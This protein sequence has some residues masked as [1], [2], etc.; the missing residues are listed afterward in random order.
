M[1]MRFVPRENCDANC[2]DVSVKASEA[3]K[4]E[5]ESCQDNVTEKHDCS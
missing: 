4:F 3:S 1:I 5:G 2:K